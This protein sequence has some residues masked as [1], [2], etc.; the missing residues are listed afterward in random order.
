MWVYSVY[1]KEIS[2]NEDD[3]KRIRRV[4]EEETNADSREHAAS[5]TY[6]ELRQGKRKVRREEDA[7]TQRVFK[8][9]RRKEAF[10]IT[11]SKKL[12]TYN[13][14]PSVTQL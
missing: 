4:F 7:A 14:G 13:S 1:K 3:E 11:T 12:L 8:T 2:N 9:N 6:A 10:K 5:A